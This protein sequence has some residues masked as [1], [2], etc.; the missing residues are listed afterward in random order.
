[1]FDG[2]T[3]LYCDRQEFQYVRK[4][5]KSHSGKIQRAISTIRHLRRASRSGNSDRWE[6]Y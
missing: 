4:D 6:D 2:S 1:M 3:Y 5:S